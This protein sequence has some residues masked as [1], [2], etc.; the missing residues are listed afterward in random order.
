MLHTATEL[1]DLRAALHQA[2]T[3]HAMLAGESLDDVPERM[4]LVVTELATNAIKY[5]RPPTVVRLLCTDDQFILDVAD[6][7]LE[8]PPE[9][10]DT[11][12]INAGGRGLMLAQKFSLEVGWYATET[13]KHVWASFPMPS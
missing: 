11:R 3:G 4:V 12:P 6:H 9:L 8:N 5:G 1:R 7:D 13:S 2:L 10:V